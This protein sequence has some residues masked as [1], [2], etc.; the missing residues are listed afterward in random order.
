[1]PLTSVIKQEPYS[2]ILNQENLS[3]GKILT[4]SRIRADKIFCVDKEL[5]KMKIGVIDE[6]V[7]KKIKIELHK[8]F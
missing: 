7:L 2:I 5:V 4:Q 3:S 6:N 8:I 1:M